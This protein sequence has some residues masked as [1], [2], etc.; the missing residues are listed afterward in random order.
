VRGGGGN[1]GIVTSFEFRLHPVNEI[2]GGLVAHTFDAAKDFLRFL[3]EYSA[4]GPDEL[5]VMPLLVHAP[6]GSGT[7]LAASAVAH[8]GPPQQAE[9]DLRPL[10]EFGSPILSQVGSISYPAL[11]TMLDD[12]FPPGASYYWKSNFVPELTDEV[13]EVMIDRFATCP[14]IMSGIAVEHLH[15]AMTRVPVTATAFPHRDPG[16]NVLVAGVWADAEKSDENIAWTRE[17]Y[18]ALRP[19]LS[20][21]RYVNY[22]SDDDVEAVPDAYGPNLRRLVEIKHRYDP[23]NLFHLNHNIEPG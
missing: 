19:L 12:G 22:L 11:N 14:S 18:Q 6:D 17:T 10:L 13:I 20:T 9:A 15:G 2:G 4:T 16:Y 5:A 21:G 3:G 1:F 8:F 7:R 23:G